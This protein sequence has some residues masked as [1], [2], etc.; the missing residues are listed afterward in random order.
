MVHKDR[1]EGLGEEWNAHFIGEWR[2]DGML[3]KIP[4]FLLF[5]LGDGHIVDDVLL[6]ATLHSVVTKLER[7]YVS[8]EQLD[9]ICSFVH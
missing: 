6:T 4:C 3:A 7:V 1:V 9:S 2:V 8:I 5:S